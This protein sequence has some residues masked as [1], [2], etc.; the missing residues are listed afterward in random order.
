MA[1]SYR[2]FTIQGGKATEGAEVGTLNIKGADVQIPAVIIGQEGRGRERGVLPVSGLQ[3][4][5]CPTRGKNMSWPDIQQTRQKD[6]SYDYRCPTCQV[7]V[8]KGPGDMPTFCVHPDAGDIPAAS[9]EFAEVG[10]TQA[11]KPKLF[12]RADAASDDFVILVMRT[13]MGYRGG[14]AHTGDRAG[15]KCSAFSCGEA[16]EGVPPAACPKCGKSENYSG[17][18]PTF[19]RFPGQ[20]IVRGH[21]AQGDAGRMG[22]GEQLVVVMPKDVVFRTAYSGRLYGGPSSHYYKW[23]GERLL[24]ATWDERAAAD[25]F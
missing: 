6:G 22:G 11:G 15:W 21:I 10:Q 25:L 13:G 17:P 20:V 16:G 3:I 4:Q 23:D 18:Q 2:V 19:A 9:I 5:P 1:D 14:N 8:E 12:A 7:G 24:S